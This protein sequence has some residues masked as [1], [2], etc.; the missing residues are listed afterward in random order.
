VPAFKCRICIPDPDE[1]AIRAK[2]Q[3]ALPSFQWQE[4]DSSW[5]KIRVWTESPIAVISIYRYES[6]GPFELSIRMPTP[7]GAESEEQSRVVRDKLLAALGAKIWKPLEPQP[8]SLIKTNGRFPATYEF[9]CGL[10]LAQVETL[11]TDSTFW[12]WERRMH[13]SSEVCL[14]GRIPFHS[15][16]K[17]LWNCSERVRLSGGPPSYKVAVGHWLN[18]AGRTPTCDQV[19]EIVQ[20]TIL[21]ALGARNLRAS[22]PPL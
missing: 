20:S 16:G 3:Q 13:N 5:D 15:S 22:E 12:Y 19:H 10:S 17:A 9:D 11:L 2:L 8:V 7:D 1:S 21:P 18:P 4:G 14:E 6:P